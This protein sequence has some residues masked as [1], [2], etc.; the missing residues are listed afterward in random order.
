MLEESSGTLK[1]YYL[2]LLPKP[3]KD[4]KFHV[5]LHPISLLPRKGKLF[6]KVIV[7]I[8]QRYLEEE[9]CLVQASLVSQHMRLTDHVTLSFI[10]NMSTAVVLLDIEE[11]FDIT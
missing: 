10:N 11:T 4:Q 1:F 9:T 5:N 2:R 3:S 8:F 7:N 6:E